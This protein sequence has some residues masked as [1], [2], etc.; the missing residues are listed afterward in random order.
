MLELEEEKRTLS[1]QREASRA[2]AQCGGIQAKLSYARLLAEFGENEG[3]HEEAFRAFSDLIVA[4]RD[5]CINPSTLEPQQRFDFSLS[6]ANFAA[7]LEARG[8]F[9]EAEEHYTL[10][11]SIE[12]TQ[13]L[14]LGNYAM[15]MHKVLPRPIFALPF[16]FSFKT[17]CIS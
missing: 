4:Y 17:T 11:L 9:D 3:W 7:F 14:A 8:S 15:F 13:A 5:T 1:W 2:K 6:A 16:S 12:P 10:A